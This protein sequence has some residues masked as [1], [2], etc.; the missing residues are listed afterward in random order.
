MP[1]CYITFIMSSSMNQIEKLIQIFVIEQLHGMLKNANASVGEQPP[2]SQPQQDVP[3]QQQSSKMEELMSNMCMSLLRIE[4]DVS[5]IVER[6]N[7]LENTP[8][9]ANDTKL[10]QPPSGCDVERP[11]NDDRE[12]HVRLVVEEINV[13]MEEDVE[14]VEKQP[15]TKDVVVIEEEDDEETS[16]NTQEA[17]QEE[18]VEVGSK[19]DEPEVVE[20][21]VVEEEVVEEEVV[22][23]EVV[24][25]EVVEEE[26]V[27]EE[28]VEEE[29]VEE[30]VVEEEVVEE[31]VEEEEVVEEEVEEEEVEEEEVVEEVLAQPLPKV[32]E[33]EEEEEEV[34]EIEIDDITYY[35]TGEENGVLYEVT[36]DGDVGKKVGVIKDGEPIFY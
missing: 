24:E 12:D 19:K 36:E 28:V 22:E 6:L 11:L 27:E 18:V 9:H 14:I 32:E 2:Q 35:A 17:I 21:E 5:N 8:L 7:V 16:V 25:E 31:E 30:E 1:L 23:E 26:V 20:E 3:I 10:T 33:E 34:F 13:K 15:K 4:K 29:V